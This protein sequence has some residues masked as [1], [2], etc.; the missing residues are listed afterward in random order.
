MATYVSTPVPALR[1][2]PSIDVADVVPTRSQVA[3][4]YLAT[5]SLPPL[6]TF[7]AAEPSG[8]DYIASAMLGSVA[9]GVM[10]V[11]GLA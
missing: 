2:R 4:A 5:G 7:L 10:L 8:T 3:A 11:A 1:R 6:R 9:V